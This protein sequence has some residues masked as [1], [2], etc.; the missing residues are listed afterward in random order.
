MSKSDPSPQEAIDKFYE[1]QRCLFDVIKGVSEC[2]HSSLIDGD[3]SPSFFV[4]HPTMVDTGEV[5]VKQK[6]YE[7][8]ARQR[9]L[10]SEKE[11]VQILIDTN[12][13]GEESEKKYKNLNIQVRN[14]ESTKSQIF[15]KSQRDQIKKKLEESQSEL[16]KIAEDRGSLLGLTLEDFVS[17]RTNT[18]SLWH[19]MYS[20]E[21]VSTRIFPRFEDFYNLLSEDVEIYQMIFSLRMG[22]FTPARLKRVAVDPTFMNSY[23]LCDGKPLEFF[24]KIAVELTSFQLSLLN[25]SGGFCN[26]LENAERSMPDDLNDCDDV[27]KW[28]EDERDRLN[29]KYSD[30]APSSSGRRT[31]ANSEFQAFSA[32]TATEDEAQSLGAIKNA[33][34]IDLKTAADE[35]KKELGKDKLDTKDMARLHGLM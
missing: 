21:S 9:G 24:G 26:V 29:S 34:V 2:S 4:K 20:D 18:F 16:K 10:K 6:E 3:T 22:F 27:I 25:L 30:S 31:S 33:P 11:L 15:L 14:L 12:N 28:L 7:G 8:V 35:L 17:N 1:D 23:M 19:C 5:A 32:P 13:W